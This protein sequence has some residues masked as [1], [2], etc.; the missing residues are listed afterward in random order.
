[1][2][3]LLSNAIKFSKDYDEIKV[4][5]DIKT[6]K[7]SQLAVKIQVIDYGIGISEEDGRK[8]FKDYF[9]SADPMS[10]A[11]N[12]SSHGLGLSICSKIAKSL[13]GELSC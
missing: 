5:L 9:R 6:N 12:A 11:R 7:S 10:R 3:N 13:N 1:M 4:K 8:L 2:I